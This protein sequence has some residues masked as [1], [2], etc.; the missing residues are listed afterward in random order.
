MRLVAMSSERPGWVAKG[1]QGLRKRLNRE[2]FSRADA[3]IMQISGD[4]G[5]I[6]PPDLQFAAGRSIREATVAA[7]VCQYYSLL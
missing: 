5:A 1:I 3:A 4:S 2:A 7:V 6:C